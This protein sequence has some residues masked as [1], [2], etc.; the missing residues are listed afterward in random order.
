[1]GDAEAVIKEATARIPNLTKATARATA[2][3]S[4]GS[5]TRS[6]LLSIAGGLRIFN[7]VRF[8]NN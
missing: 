5:K 8:C 3:I 1:M 4:P 6:Y 2:L 7:I